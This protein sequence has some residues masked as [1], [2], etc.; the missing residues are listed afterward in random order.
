MRGGFFGHAHGVACHVPFMDMDGEAA[1][2]LL[3]TERHP[4]GKHP[5]REPMALEESEQVGARAV[6]H[7][8]AHNG[9][10]RSV[11]THRQLCVIILFAT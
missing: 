2:L 6:R 7:G 4:R 5:A 11:T 8:T 10:L 3:F 9:R 1:R